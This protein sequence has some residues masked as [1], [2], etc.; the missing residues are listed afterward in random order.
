MRRFLLVLAFAGLGCGKKE[1]QEIK[2]AAENA[3]AGDTQATHYVQSLQ[4]D[5]E[6]AKDAKAKAE[7]AI[8]QTNQEVD[9]AATDPAQ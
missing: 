1:V 4:N 3:K 7:G 5:V 8:Q 6:K 2:K 9:K